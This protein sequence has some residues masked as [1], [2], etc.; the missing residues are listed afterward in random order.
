MMIYLNSVFFG[1]CHLFIQKFHQVFQLPLPPV[2]HHLMGTQT[3][4]RPYTENNNHHIYIS[5]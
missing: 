2:N 4:E 3:I 1:F 5:W